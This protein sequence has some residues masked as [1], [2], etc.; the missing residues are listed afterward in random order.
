MSRAQAG[1]VD[2]AIADIAE[3]TKLSNWT[4]D[5]WHTFA[6]VYAAASSKVEG[7][8]QEYTDRAME[9]LEQA[10]KADPGVIAQLKQDPDLAPL[11]EREDFLKLI[12]ELKKGAEQK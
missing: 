1:Q 5:H 2:V 9:L 4:A 10:V 3:L 6:R 7:K 12:G 11:R 8:Q